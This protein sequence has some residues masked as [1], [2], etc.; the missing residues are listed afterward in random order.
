MVMV[1]EI[2]FTLFVILL[3]FFF[4]LLIKP[5]HLHIIFKNNNLEYNYFAFLKILIFSIFIRYV[6][7]R[8]ILDFKLNFFSH[9]FNLFKTNINEK[10]SEENLNS[11]S[12]EKENSSKGSEE[13]EKTNN[14]LLLKIKELYPL[15]IQSKEDLMDLI[16]VII[17]I[18]KFNESSSIINL[19][20]LDN[21]LTIKICTIIWALTAPL[22]SLNFRVFLTPEIDKIIIK[23][24]SNIEFDIFFIN[25][26]KIAYIIITREHLRNLIKFFIN[27]V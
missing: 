6:N 9:T 17:K 12:E 10:E 1:I 15:L 23:T 20:V 2:I 4:L 19:G 21:N 13:K 8:L 16:N 27:R 18:V 14:E 26:L 22:Y 3:V 24:D 11:D 5:W 25:I 7:S